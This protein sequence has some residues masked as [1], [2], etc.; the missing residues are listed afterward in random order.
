VENGILIG[1]PSD[2]CDG[3]SDSE[4]WTSAN[5]ILVEAGQLDYL[6][7]LLVVSLTHP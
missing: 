2:G 6:D 7:R 4:W 5:H 1:G 3:N